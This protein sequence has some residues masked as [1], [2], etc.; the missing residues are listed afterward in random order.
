MI[1]TTIFIKYKNSKNEK[2]KTAFR[3]YNMLQVIVY[4]KT[5]CAQAAQVIKQSPDIVINWATLD[6]NLVNSLLL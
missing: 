6:E 4:A 5:V 1:P 2:R 3:R